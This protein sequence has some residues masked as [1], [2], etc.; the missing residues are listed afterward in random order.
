MSK[1]QFR[2]KMRALVVAKQAALERM[3]NNA[4]QYFKVDTF[5]KTSFDGQK[6][7]ERKVQDQSRQMLVKTGRM[8]QDIRVTERGMNHRRVGTTVPYAKYHNEGTDRLPQRKFIGASRWL[9]RRNG[10]EVLRALKIVFK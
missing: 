1:F 5:D 6:W 9:Y 7:K 2:A 3:G 8:R 4:V 10:V